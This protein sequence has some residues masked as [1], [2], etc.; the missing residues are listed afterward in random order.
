MIRKTLTAVGAALALTAGL[1]A[2]AFAA[3][4]HNIVTNSVFFVNME[5]GDGFDTFGDFGDGPLAQGTKV[6]DVFLFFAPPTPYSLIEFYGGAPDKNASHQ[7]TFKFTGFD[8]GVLNYELTDA[9]F[10][11]TGINGT[12]YAMD[13]ASFNNVWR[14]T[15]RA[16]TGSAAASTTSKSRAAVTRCQRRLQRQRVHDG[17]P[18]ADEHRPD[19]GR[20]RLGRPMAR[21]R[22]QQ[23]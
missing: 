9:D 7:N 4:D 12:S 11:V 13:D 18:R 1:A 6:D 23:A 22:K 3:A 21:R 16:T 8:Y 19:A 10:N 2:P 20:H 17:R 15:A 5:F 14:S